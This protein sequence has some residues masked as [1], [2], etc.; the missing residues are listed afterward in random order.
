MPEKPRVIRSM[1][2]FERIYFPR[3]Y[4]KKQRDARIKKVGLGVVW[5]EEALAKVF[6][7]KRKRK[8]NA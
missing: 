3:D 1:E 8:A 5:A 2:E 6:G 4:A 7:K